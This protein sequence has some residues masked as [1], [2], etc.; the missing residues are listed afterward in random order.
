MYEAWTNK[1]ILLYLPSHTTHAL[2]PLDVAVFGPLKLRYHQITVNW[3]CF[4]ISAPIA[5]QNFLMAYEEASRLAFTPENGKAGFKATGIQPLN[6]KK[7]LDIL[8]LFVEDDSQLQPPEPTRPV[9]PPPSQLLSDLI[10][11]PNNGQ[12]VAKLKRRMR[13]NLTAVDRAKNKLL[14][15]CAKSLDL[16]NTRIAILEAENKRLAEEVRSR[17]LTRRRKVQPDPN[18]RF[19]TIESIKKAQDE[20]HQLQETGRPAT[21]TTAI[22]EEEE[23]EESDISSPEEDCIIVRLD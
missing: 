2:Q 14:S 6:C 16:K 5:K 17:K 8:G 7:V 18:G 13:Q 19:A 20:L 3:A 21:R 4:D 11:T 9:T 23:E 15:K 12:Q 10:T 1:V 22:S